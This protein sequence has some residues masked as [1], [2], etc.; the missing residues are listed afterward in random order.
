MARNRAIDPFNPCLEERFCRCLRLR[1]GED[2][3]KSAPKLFK[4]NSTGAP[5]HLGNRTLS[6]GEWAPLTGNVTFG[7]PT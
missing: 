6:L 3:V 5:L 7:F 1:L 2:I 4:V